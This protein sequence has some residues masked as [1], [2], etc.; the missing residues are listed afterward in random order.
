MIG[1]RFARHLDL[2]AKIGLVLL[3]VIVPTFVVVTIAQ[4][5]LTRP[6]LEED[7]RQIG[8]Q[9]G[10]RL[11]AEIVSD[12]LLQLPKPTPVIEARVQEMLYTQPNIVRID[13]IAKDPV[14]GTPRVVATNIEEDPE[15]K[16]VPPAAFDLVEQTASEYKVDENGVGFWD[17]HVPIEQKI[18]HSHS[19]I[20][21]AVHVVISTKLV[22]RFAITLWKATIAAAVFSMFALLL[23]LGYFLRKTIQNDRKLRQAE[24]QNIQLT[25]QLHEAERQIMNTEK[26]AVMGQLT[27][28]FAHE[29]GTPL[30]AIGG[31]LQLLKDEIPGEKAS[32][33]DRVDIIDGQLQ[34]I[35]GIVKS[36][37]Q[38]TAKPPSQ[39]QL[40]DLNQIADKTLR[41]LKPRTES[42]GVDVKRS[43]DR[44]LGP[45]RVVPLDLEQILL[46]LMNNSLDSMGSK[47]E[48]SRAMLEVGTDLS[49]R[50]G[51]QW[52]EIS[53]YD[54]GEGI[55]KADLN[56]VLKPFFTT[57][58][59][60]EG[61]GLG[62]TIC[63]QLAHKYGGHLEIESK[64]SQWTRV[65]LRL[66]YQANA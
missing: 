3:G 28:S 32:S 64:E 29:I 52:A 15:D 56:N 22:G 6:I 61:T 4:N 50:E 45:I 18:P 66:P 65:K 58:P 11:A 26:M 31:H 2:Q 12:R 21:G 8:E 13:V 55:K 54:T 39:R 33:L 44:N 34:K 17:I 46:N 5:K 27:A 10:G 30:T 51:K 47:R 57:K 24:T 38:S 63:Q 40:V 1:K 23:G 48:K 62:L 41:I 42:M 35:E 53:V 49:N 59:P 36:F 9:S 60:G 14:T 19:R 43:Y 25:E 37:L 20:L 16:E 7:I